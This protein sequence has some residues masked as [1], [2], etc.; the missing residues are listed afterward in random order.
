[1]ADL[2][3]TDP[4]VLKGMQAQLK[5]R[6]A[7]LRSGS[8]ALGWKAGFGAPA[9]LEAFNL[10]GPLVGFMLAEAKVSSGTA[11]SLDGWIKPVAEPEIAIWFGEDVTEPGDREKVQSAISGIGPAI[12]LADLNPPPEDVTKILEGN[13]FH[14]HVI[15]GACDTS[16]A[17]ADLQGLTCRVTRN[18]S[19]LPATSELETNTGR[20]LDVAAWTAATLA[21]CGETIRA[22]DVL[23]CGS[24]IP[25]LFIEADDQQLQ[26]ALDP[27]AP[28]NVQFAR[29]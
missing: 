17:G 24:I 11:V 29:A 12:E 19:E 18:G 4:R 25:P 14:R 21:A 3:V 23:I 16:R 7:K 13:I 1:M 9:A 27:M 15:L 5:S 20:I 10:S 26:H 6:E 22:G 8:K 28:V 2:H